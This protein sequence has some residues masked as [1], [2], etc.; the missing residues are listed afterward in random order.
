MPNDRPSRLRPLPR[1]VTPV[2]NETVGSYI[3]RLAKANHMP[4][5]NLWGLVKER[6][7]HRASAWAD[8]IA[9]LSGIPVVSLRYAMLELCQP[10]DLATMNVIGR[11]RPGAYQ[12]AGCRLCAASANVVDLDRIRVWARHEDVVCLRHGQWTGIDSASV[13]LSS[14]SE[15]VRA[16]RL[17]RYL[18]RRH[19]RPEV[20]RVFIDVMKVYR[21]EINDRS[22]GDP[23]DE[24]MT[25]FRGGSWGYA[26]DNG[27]INACIY[28]EAVGLTRLLSS[29]Y[30]SSMILDGHMPSDWSTLTYFQGD[31]VLGPNDVVRTDSVALLRSSP[32][33]DRFVAEARR[34]AS[35][36]FQWVPESYY[37]GRFRPFTKWVIDRLEERYGVAGPHQERLYLQR[38]C[39][40]ADIIEPASSTLH[41]ERQDPLEG[42]AIVMR[43][44]QIIK[45]Y[46]LGVPPEHGRV[47]LHVMFRRL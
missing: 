6:D 37:R 2:L 11:P 25:R 43:G 5:K 29:G 16:N 22:F 38:P 28:P 46:P 45:Q 26:F 39:P 4:A 33:I 24:R 31:R 14:H 27:L 17:H 19:G 35:E 9:S 7:D 23:F 40:K 32:D 21:E 10:E 15:I 42:R 1:R 18:I 47:G 30:W 12:Q 13:D 41:H 34:T 44:S 20:H 36:G 8:S 3:G